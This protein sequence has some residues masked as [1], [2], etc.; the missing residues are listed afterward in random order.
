MFGLFNR[1]IAV[2]YAHKNTGFRASQ[3]S[4][5]DFNRM[6]S[7]GHQ[8]KLNL[9]T[10][11]NP[12]APPTVIKDLPLAMMGDNGPSTALRAAPSSFWKNIKRNFLHMRH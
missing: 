1:Y 9:T 6:K 11:T 5:E 3:L 7:M 4:R 8:E 10:S 12:F 2:D